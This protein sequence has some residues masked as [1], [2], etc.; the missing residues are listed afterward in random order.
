MQ[1]MYICSP[2][3]EL[4]ANFQEDVVRDILMSSE[5]QIN[6]ELE[7]EQLKEDHNIMRKIFPTGNSKVHRYIVVYSC[8]G[9]VLSM[10][11]YIYIGCVTDEFVASNLECAEDF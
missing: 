10:C 11:L 3:R 7:F 4:R 9:A 8:H 2:C 5:A 1:I 6:L